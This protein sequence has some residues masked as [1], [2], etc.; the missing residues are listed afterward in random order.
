MAVQC[1]A[2]HDILFSP[3]PVHDNRIDPFALAKPEVQTAIHRRFK[4]AHRHLFLV[5]QR[6]IVIHRY[7][8]ADPVTVLPFSIQ[9]YPH[10]G[11]LRVQ[12]TA[13]VPVH[14]TGHVYIIHHQVQRPVVI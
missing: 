11:I 13:P 8:G 2:F 4:P 6:M 10:I 14:E 9:F 12:F 1:R 3:G 7:P 5:G